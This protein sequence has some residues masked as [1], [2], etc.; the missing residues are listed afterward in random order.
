MQQTTNTPTLRHGYEPASVLFLSNERPQIEEA[1]ASFLSFLDTAPTTAKTYAKAL[2][3]FFEWLEK[4]KIER[5]T[6]EDLIAY[7]KEL[8]ATR[9]STTTASY[10]NALKQF[11]KWLDYNG[12]Y[13]NIAD[14]LKGAKIER[15]HRKDPLTGA[16]ARELLASVDA[17]TIEGLRDRAIIALAIAAA[18]RTVEIV[19]ADIADLHYISGFMALSI[20]GKGKTD[21]SDFVKV[22]DPIEKVIREYLAARGEQDGSAPL[23][24]S[25]SDRNKGG[26][27]TTNSISRIVK[28]ALRACGLDSP[29]LTAHSMRHTGATLNLLNG[30]TLQETQQLL[31]HA[32]IN[33][34]MI[35]NHALDRAANQSE[36]RIANILF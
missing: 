17:S 1:A 3:V 20:Q 9:K 2:K 22:P 6:R 31:R 15:G 23:F 10:I 16:Q 8:L 26:R 25:V 12:I 4:E 30:G 34:T 7:R 36:A 13:K 33:T 32:S 24:A 14:H 11:F 18:L 28:K 5:P 35:Y 21:K 29:R 27:L 19:R